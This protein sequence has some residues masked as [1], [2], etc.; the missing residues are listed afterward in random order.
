[1]D[2]AMQP[3]AQA[4]QLV[5]GRYRLE[6]VLATGGMARVWEATDEVLSRK[7]AVKVLHP[8]LAADAGFVARFRAEAVAAARLAHPSIVAIF[9][10]C[11]DGLEAIVMELVRG[12]NLRRYLD[13]R[14]PLE[15]AEA[16][17]IIAQVADALEVAH[18]S[19][20]VHRDVKPANILLADDGRVLVADFGIA[21]AAVGNGGQDLT[22]TGDTLGTVKYLAP[23]QVEGGAVDARTDVYAL[24]LV[25]YEAMCGRPA[26]VADTDAATALARLHQEPLRPRQVRA[27][28]PRDIEAVVLKA[29]ARP[30]ADRYPTAIEFRAALLAASRGAMATSRTDVGGTGPLMAPVAAPPPPTAP[31][32]AA[33][34]VRRRRRI[35][36]PVLVIGIIVAG[37]SVAGLLLSRTDAG[38]RLLDGDGGGTRTN[39][40]QGITTFDPLGDGREN[41]DE[42]GKAI[43]GDPTTFWS[44]EGYDNRLLGGLKAG[45]GLVISVE[46]AGPLDSLALSTRITGWAVEIYVAPSPAAA[47]ADGGQ[48]VASGSDLGEV[49]DFD[50]AGTEGGAVL[51]WFTD[52]GNAPPR[53]HAE[54]T[55][56]TVTA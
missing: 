27:G 32:P 4:G 53:V 23:E 30:P 45:V 31:V 13:E 49:V 25:L 9:D 26:F 3:A 15:P 19:G 40:V 5:G 16:V 6:R 29:I 7:V 38:K 21:K 1:V 20:V 42:V 44:S 54:I 18:R 11:S 43:D 39:V 46:P 12:T 50:L 36:G 14:G 37:A 52:L 34:G 2:E 28:I 56:V 47:R 10:T 22:T 33:A 8:H 24:G 55:E 51:V 17:G 35:V 41:D 48:P